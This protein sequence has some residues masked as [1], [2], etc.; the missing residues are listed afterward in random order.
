MARFQFSLR[1][2][3]IGIVLAA[4]ALLLLRF[5]FQSHG[6]AVALVVVALGVLILLLANAVIYAV[7]RGLGIIFGLDMPSTS[8]SEARPILLDQTAPGT[9]GK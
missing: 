2:L 7:L 3:L 8:E 1:Q 5:A 9:D 6:A 4:I